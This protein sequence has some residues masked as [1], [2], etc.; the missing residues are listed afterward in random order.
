MPNIYVRGHLVQIYYQ[1]TDTHT[2]DWLLSSGHTIT[3]TC[4]VSYNVNQLVNA[5]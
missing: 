2:S 4:K 1:N 5:H 3:Y